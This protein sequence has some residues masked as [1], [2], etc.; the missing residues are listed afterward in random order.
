MI[1][2]SLKTDADEAAK[3]EIV[4]RCKW[5][6]VL[7]AIVAEASRIPSGNFDLRQ[8]KHV[9]PSMCWCYSIRVKY[10]TICNFHECVYTSMHVYIYIYIYMGK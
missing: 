3:W 6:G 1:Q 8:A 10:N 4:I 2:S 7:D 5:I 9:Q